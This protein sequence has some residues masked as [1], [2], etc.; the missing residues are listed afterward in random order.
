MTLARPKGLAALVL[1]VF[2]AALGANAGERVVIRGHVPQIV[3]QIPPKGRLHGTQRIH[4]AVG[5]ASRDEQGLENFLKEVYDPASTNY[6]HYLSQEQFAARFGPAEKDYRALADFASA[7]H[8]AVTRQYTNRVVLD[9]EGTA[10][11]IETAFQIHLSTYQHPSEPRTFFAPDSEPSV[12]SEIPVS[13]I[14][15]LNNYILPHPHHHHRQS[16][17]AGVVAKAGT[18]P[19]GQLWG[20][21]FRKAYVP[22]TKLTGAG[23]SLGLVEFEGYY[24]SD[25]V[26]YE[27]AI[28]ISSSARPELVVVSLEGGATPADGGDNGEECSIDIEMAVA[29]APG[30]SKIYVFEDGGEYESNSD[31]DDVFEA[32]VS[33][34][35]I[36][37]F[38]CSWGGDTSADPASELL[39]KQ[40]AAQ[41]QSFFNASGDAGAFVGPV[42]FPS[43]SPSIMQVG[44]TT[45]TIG[46]SPNYA[47]ASEK[48]WAWDSG[49]RVSA[50]NA[51]SSSG[52]ISTYYGIP[53]WQEGISMSANKGSA[54]MRNSPDIAANA[55]NCYIYSDDGQ[56]SGGWGGTSCAAPLWAAYAALMNQLAATNG[57]SPVG[58]LNP[59]LYALATNGNYSANFHDVT[60]GNNTWLDSPNSF[61]AEAG[62]DLCT[63]WGSMKGISLMAALIGVFETN[64]DTAAGSI[65]VTIEPV[66]AVAAGAKWNVDGGSYKKSGAIAA[67]ISIGSHTVAFESPSGWRAPDSQT[68]TVSAGSNSTLSATYEQVGSLKVTLSPGSLTNAGAGWQVDGGSWQQSGAVLG[69]LLAG[70]HTVAFGSIAGWT[71]P[72]SVT[73]AIKAGV[74]AKLAETYVLV[75]PG[76]YNGLFAATPPS[77]LTSG[78]LQNLVVG[79]NG[80]YSGKL[81][82]NG[83]SYALSGGLTS[84]PATKVIKRP[85]AAGGPVILSMALNSSVSPPLITGSVSASNG[86]WSAG[87]TNEIS[88]AP[89]ASAEFTAAISPGALPGYGCILMTNHLGK[90][91]LAGSLADGVAFSQMAPL[92][93]SGNVPVCMSLR[94]GA[95]LLT[96][97]LTIENGAPS[98]TLAWMRKAA[99]TGIYPRGFTNSVAVTGSAWLASQAAAGF[100]TG[101]I[102][103][104]SGGTLPAALNFPVSFDK[105]SLVKSSG[106]PTSSL[107]GSL[108]PKTGLLKVVFGN[109]V[110]K[111]TSSGSAVLL[112]GSSIGEGFFLGKTNGG[113]I[114]LQ[115]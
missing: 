5:L 99:P 88:A 102:L 44:G 93:E 15:G 52:G 38:S 84:G 31:F 45:L 82:L 92:S 10:S 49:P 112:Q 73:V 70:S 100:V 43:D 75:G 104:V 30:L 17:P 11:D 83:A 96:G 56:R 60:S 58:F 87:L 109:G 65:E 71:T 108:N 46:G 39:F 19:G 18:A 68:V 29:M 67:D 48:V 78:M 106:A 66:A 95:E 41:G 86:A 33:R 50:E 110:G 2:L 6:H 74:E 28:G 81:L 12:P 23:Q 57:L 7:N 22:G 3:S 9:V 90:I 47:W 63:G 115:P 111:S 76:T 34:P 97:W 36:L 98:G 16:L 101:D 105:N 72:Q 54:T 20:N 51:T 80:I 1:L 8:L 40:M 55:D 64:S 37:Q 62:F 59:A 94:G 13:H 35:E 69:N 113:S 21:D 24:P 25:I 114:L 27:N 77:L 53:V 26:A 85:D 89:G 79:K 14:A 4:L 61:D 42:Y 91:T 32:M 107:T 103:S